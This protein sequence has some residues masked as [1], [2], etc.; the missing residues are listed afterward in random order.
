MAAFDIDLMS[1]LGS[2]FTRT[3]GGPNSG[4]HVPPEWYIQ[5]G[6]DLGAP[7][8]TQVRA[9]FDGQVSRFHPHDPATDSGKVY[10]AQI[11]V[12]DK[13]DR[14]G[15]FYTHL[16]NV[17]E[18]LAQGGAVSRGEVIGEVFEFGG[19]PGHVHMAVC[20]IFGDV[21]T[22]QRVGV[23]LHDLFVALSGTDETAT[24]TFF[25]ESGRAPQRSGAGGEPAATVL[26]LSTV[27]GIQQAL[28]AL[29]FDPGPI[30]GLDGPKTQ[31]AVAAFQA[32]NGLA[33]QDG[34]TTRDTV[35]ALAAHLDQHGIGSIGI[36]G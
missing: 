2:G 22:G 12:R 11:F 20:E 35:A 15:C 21:A 23:D 13:S 10:G 24:V 33:D 31:A 1:P 32:A 28:T 6:M 5:F 19:I 17:P 18:T 4:G 16:T 7:S 27:H 14:M 3:L 8:G 36:D 30:D 9:A 26:D 34:T 25:Q 29:G